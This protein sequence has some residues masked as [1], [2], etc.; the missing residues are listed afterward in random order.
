M[1]TL[2]LFNW[3]FFHWDFLF[4]FAADQAI[5]A[6]FRVLVKF[7]K[8]FLRF[9]LFFKREL[10]NNLHFWRIY[11]PDRRFANICFSFTIDGLSA[12]ALPDL[13]RLVITTYPNRIKQI[14]SR[15]RN[16]TNPSMTHLHVK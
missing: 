16:K 10:R 13:P 4:D 14:A 9:T 1:P 6:A 15:P 11:I 5:V 7:G 2:W 3:R 12:E 8:L